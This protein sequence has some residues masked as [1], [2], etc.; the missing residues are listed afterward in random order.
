MN[1]ASGSLLI[2]D[3]DQQNRT[4]LAA[5]LH[6]AGHVTA[7]AA[8]GRQA[9]EMLQTQ[10][11]D[12]VLLDLLMPE[13]D[14]YQVL[15]HLQADDNLR[16]IP[17]IVLAAMDDMDSIV[18]GLEMG[19]A[20]YLPKP[21]HAVLLHTRVIACLE[22]KHL[23]DQQAI[24]LQQ[25][26]TL[27][28][29]PAQRVS[30]T[31]PRLTGSTEVQEQQLRAM[32]ATSAISLAL[33]SL[34]DVDELLTLVMDKS[35]EVM[36]AEAS[37][38]LM[39]DQ[40]ASLLRFHVAR[41]TA[42]AALRSATVALGHGIAGWVA[43]TGAPLLIPDAYQDPRFDPSY[44]KRS[45]FRTRSI[46]TVPLKVKDEVTGVVQVINKVGETAFDQHDLDLFLSFASQASVALDNA[47][48]YERTKAMAEDLRQALEQERRLTVI[49]EQQLREMEAMSAVSLAMSSLL[50]PHELLTMVMD[51]SKEVMRAEASSLLML[52]QEASLLR[53]HVARG[54]AGEALRSATVALGHGIA[55][56]VAQTGAP[57]LIPDAYQDPRFDPSY[58]KRSG[59]R[60]RSIL[61]VPLKVKDEVTGVVQVINKVGE[62]AFDQHDLD[63]FLSFASQASVAL[64]NARLYERTK[65]MAEDL[66]QALEQE[67][68]LT[69][70]KEKMGAYIPKQ[71][72]DEISRNREQKLALG[73][74]NV[75]LTILFSDIQGFT[76]L[77]ENMASQQVI[78]FLNTY[79]TAMT[80]II[81]EEGGIIDKFIGDGIMAVF[82][83]TS[84]DDNHALRAVRA[85]MR[86]QKQLYSLRQEWATSRPE[87]AG[88]QIRV[89]VNTGEVVSGNIGSETRMDYTVVGDNVNVASRLESVSRAGEVCISESTY[90]DVEGLIA[91][92][93]LEPV[94]VK[95]RMQ[96][97]HVYTIQV[98]TTDE[99]S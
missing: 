79:M 23:C 91:A 29:T 40:E 96:P 5:R 14:G 19:A 98:S 57:L 37:S 84:E 34:M 35:K 36:R 32:E 55:G 68:R 87:L 61:T 76:R 28:E 85:G 58:D 86:M 73:G 22:K 13:M 30:E 53:F 51:K 78:G 56:W 2:V 77:S 12:L 62:T 41:G 33:T 95:N 26:Q 59:F 92:T 80:T 48:L 93:K 44:D 7:M 49:Q 46:L 17:V 8:N 4:L 6:S 66:R 88:M 47:R 43:Q 71:L 60:T 18:R 9:L 81:E 11:F 39:L 75:N 21:F 72:V 38:L 94:Y 42:G 69:I 52:D 67:R 82:T 65:A 83:P 63:L 45:G 90:R 20:D 50:D 31:M 24:Y 70:E 16:H 25:L 3:D 1:T 64:D 10:P 97:V 74:K 54:T 15:E 89:G 99:E 27:N